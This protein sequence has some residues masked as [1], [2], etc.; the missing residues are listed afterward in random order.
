MLDLGRNLCSASA[1]LTAIHTLAGSK[2]QRAMRETTTLWWVSFAVQHCHNEPPH[3]T[4]T[5]L[6]SS[7]MQRLSTSIDSCTPPNLSLSPNIHLTMRASNLRN[8]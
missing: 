5:S 8:G 2:V 1:N 7:Q 6:T 3:V 4:G